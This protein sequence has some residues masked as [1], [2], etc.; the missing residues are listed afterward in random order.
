MFLSTATLQFPTAQNIF[1]IFK[2]LGLPGDLRDSL[3]LPGGDCPVLAGDP[4]E[5]AVQ[6]VVLGEVALLHLPSDRDQ[7]EAAASCQHLPLRLI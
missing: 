1:Y 2:I 5:A 4:E 7:E 3:L 6:G